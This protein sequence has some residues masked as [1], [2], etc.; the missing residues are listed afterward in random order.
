MTINHTRAL[1]GAL[2]QKDPRAAQAAIEQG[3]DPN[4][5]VE[6][7]RPLH[8]A[9]IAGSK[10]MVKLLTDRGA[11]PDGPDGLGRTALHYAALGSPDADPQL[12][13]FLIKAGADVN[14][15]DSNGCTPLDLAAGAENRRTAVPLLRTGAVCKPDRLAW[16]QQV[17]GEGHGRGFSPRGRSR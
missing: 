10:E 13:E 11:L 5:M 16:V 8:V 3:A 2:I 12:I 4:A 7:T 9:T 6:G 14:V 17:S 15:A 1:L